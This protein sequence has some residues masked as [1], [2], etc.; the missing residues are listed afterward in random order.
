MPRPLIKRLRTG[1]LVIA[2]A[3][4]CMTVLDYVIGVNS[5]AMEFAKRVLQESRSMQASIGNVNEVKLR[6]FWGYAHKSGYGNATAKLRLTVIGERQTQSVSLSLK[7]VSGQ[8]MIS[9]SSVPL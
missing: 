6:K 2:S 5:D 9:S 7:Q 1:A 8:W 4:L 3:F